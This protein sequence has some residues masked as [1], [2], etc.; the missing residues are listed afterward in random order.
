[1]PQH[2]NDEPLETPQDIPRIFSIHSV[3]GGVG[4]TSVALAA[5]GIIAAKFNKKTL[6]IDADLTGASFIDVPIWGNR[7]P[8]YEYLNKLLLAN[9]NDFARYTAVYNADKGTGLPFTQEVPGHNKLLFILPSS[10]LSQ[11]IAR[12]VPLISQE[13]TLHFF[14]HRLEDIL[15]KAFH[16]KFEAVIIDHPPGLYGISLA[17]LGIVCEQLESRNNSDD[18]KTTRLDHFCRSFEKIDGKLPIP[19][20]AVFITSP[21]PS[22][23]RALFS[24]LSNVL[25]EREDQEKLQSFL[26]KINKGISVIL[27]KAQS[28]SGARFDKRFAYDSILKNLDFSEG[29]KRNVHENLINYLKKT[30]SK[31]GATACNFVSGHNCSNIK[32]AIEKLKFVKGFKP[33]DGGMEEWCMDVAISMRLIQDP[34]IPKE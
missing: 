18:Q 20:Q 21:D 31:F 27:N 17:S 14:K 23:Y 19:A 22:D 12:V 1:M 26:P 15:V 3:K 24:S 30:G 6:I 34:S 25:L 13:D 4:K 9:P 16:D 2:N 11:D 5:G 29:D 28:L 32:D 8:T 10:P 7:R 33:K